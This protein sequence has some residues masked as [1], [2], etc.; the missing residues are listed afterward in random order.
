MNILEHSELIAHGQKIVW[1]TSWCLDRFLEPQSTHWI[2][3]SLRSL[4][5]K[6]S[7]MSSWSQASDLGIQLKFLLKPLRCCAASHSPFGGRAPLTS[8]DD[9][10]TEVWPP[11][12]CLACP[13]QHP[14]PPMAEVFHNAKVSYQIR[15]LLLCTY[16]N[17]TKIIWVI[18]RVWYVHK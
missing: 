1:W 2:M 13:D 11:G 10:L 8:T 9:V 12:L 15:T 14:K 17:I 4:K 3:V 5:R 6:S 16:H 18:I 7:P